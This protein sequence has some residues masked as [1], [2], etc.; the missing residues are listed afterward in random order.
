MTERNPLPRAVAA[1]MMAEPERCCEIAW[2]WLRDDDFPEDSEERFLFRLLIDAWE[3]SEGKFAGLGPK[4]QQLVTRFF[5]EQFPEKAESAEWWIEEYF[6]L[7]AYSSVRHVFE[8][9]CERLASRSQMRRSLSAVRNLFYYFRG[10]TLEPPQG[11]E[12]YTLSRAQTAIDAALDRLREIRDG[13]SAEE[14]HR[15]SR[16]PP[17][18]IPGIYG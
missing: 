17:H 15:E 6:A 4:Y 9:L 8:W 1:G 16:R 13:L 7:G 2:L 10:F 18:S 12:P 3:L 5:A 11:G 14:Q